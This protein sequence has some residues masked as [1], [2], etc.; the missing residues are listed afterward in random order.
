MEWHE[1]ELDSRRTV[2]F[3]ERTIPGFGQTDPADSGDYMGG[4]IGDGQW[5]W[6]TCRYAKD[7]TLMVCSMATGEC[8]SCHCFWREDADE[9]E[10]EHRSSI[11]CVEEL[12]PGEP[13]RSGLL[14][15]C[16]ESWPNGE[17]RPENCPLAS[18]QVLI[19]AI[20]SG[21][22]LRSFN[23]QDLHC[24]ALAFL[25]QRICGG[26]RLARFDGCLLVATEEGMVQLVDLNGS[27]LMEKRNSDYSICQSPSAENEPRYG[28]LYPV[29]C[30]EVI[31][32]IDVLLD[33][34]RSKGGHLAVQ[35]DVARTGIRCLMGI[36]IAPGFAA[37]LEDGRVLIYDL[38]RFNVTASL[39]PPKKEGR[40]HGAVE[41]MCL[42]MPPDDPKPCFYICVMYHSAER[43]NMLLHSVNYRRSYVEQDGDG[44]RFEHFHSS[45]VRNHQVFDGE[46]CSV[47]ACTTASTFSFA[48]D[49][50][51]LLIIMAWYST[52][53]RKNKLVLFDINQWYKDEMP[54]CVR[55]YEVPHYIAG[56]FLSQNGLNGLP[57]GLGLQL[58]PNSIMHFVS[59]QRYDEHFYPDSLTFDCKLLTP[60]GSR[61]YAQNGVQHRFLNALRWERAALF[62]R[63]QPYHEDIVRLRLLPQFCELNPNATFSKAAMY[64]VILSVALEHKCSALLNDCARSWLDGSFLCNMIE[65]TELSLSTLTN[66]IM[67]R[68]GQIKQRCAELCQG[69]FDYGGYSLD[70]RERRE[71]EILATQLRELLRLQTYIVELGT[72]RLSPTVLSECQTNRRALQTVHEFHRVLYW[73]IEQA[74]LPE[75]Q[76]EDHRQHREP[77]LVSLRRDYSE[78]RTLRKNLYIDTLT[79]Q[80]GLPSTYPPESLKALLLVMLE[81]Y[82]E[83]ASKH[84]LVL[85]L[86]LDLNPPL[87][88][89]FQAN[90]ELDE[91]LAKS[92]RSFWSLDRGDCTG[93]VNELY[94]DFAMS[95]NLEEWQT[96]LLLEGLL[97]AGAVKAAMRVVSQPP[98]PIPAALH[99][100][101]LLANGS[102]PEAFEKARLH[103]RDG[104]AGQSLLELFFRYC[105]ER[106]RFKVLAELC[107]REQE[108]AL[109]YRLLRQCRSRQTECVQ[110]ILLLQKSKFVEAVSLMDQVAAD[111]ER[112]ESS[113]TIISAYRSTMAP[114]AQNIAGT[115]MRIRGNLDGMEEGCPDAGPLLPFSCQL[116]QQN[117]SGQ[118]GGIFQSSAVSAHWATHCDATASAPV[119]MPSAIGYSNIPFL[120]HE[121]FGPP[122]HLQRLPLVKPVPHQSVEKRQREEQEEQQRKQQQSQSQ[123][124]LQPRKR[125][126][127]LAEQLLED[128]RGHIN[129]L[130]DHQS[131]QRELEDAEQNGASDLLQLPNFLHARQRTESDS[132][133]SS[134]AHQAIPTILKRQSTVTG[135]PPAATST[136]LA[137]PKRFRFMPP[138]P[139][140]L[141][142]SMAAVHE[143]K[144]EQEEEDEDETDEIIV[145]IESRSEPRSAD[146]SASDEFCSPM[147]SANV[148]LLDQRD[149]PRPMIPPAGPQPRSSLLQERTSI[150]S[151]VQRAGGLGT[152]SESSSGFGSFATVQPAQ[153]TSHSQFVPTV[154]S[155]KMGETQSQVFFAGSGLVRISERTT[156]CGEMESTELGSELMAAPSSQ[157]SLPAERPLGQIGQMMDTTLGMSTY[158]V[159]PE[160]QDDGDAEE[161]EEELKLGET[162]SPEQHNQQDEEEEGEQVRD[163]EQERS[164]TSGYQLAFLAN[165]SEAPATSEPLS[166]PTCSLSSEESDMSSA[167]IRNPLLPSLPNDD[168]MY[169]IVVESTGSITTSR[170]VTHTPTSFLPSDTNVSQN[171]SPRGAAHGD[172]DGDG[173]PISL[174]RANSLETVDDL[175]T[176]KGS[177]EEEEDGYDEDD[178]VIALDGTEVRGYVARPQ[179]SAACSSAELFA[180]K[181]DCQQQQ[182]QEEAASGP[183]PS[184]SLGAT[185]NSD[186]VVAE[187]I[188][189][190][191]D[192]DEEEEEE[193]PQP[194][195]DAQMEQQKEPDQQPME[196]DA[197]SND[198]VNTVAFS[199]PKQPM[200]VESEIELE[201][202]Q[203]GEVP[204]EVMQLERIPE[205]EAE[206]DEDAAAVVV[207]EDVI[208]MPTDEVIN[209]ANEHI[210][211]GI[212]VVAKEEE[213]I[214][215]ANEEVIEEQAEE[216]SDKP[217][218]EP[219]EKPLEEPSE[220]STPLVKERTEERKKPHSSE[221][222]RAAPL[223]EQEEDLAGSLVL[224]LSDDEEPAKAPAPRTRS[225]RSSNVDSPRALRPRRGSLEHSDSPVPGT[226][227]SH[228]ILVR[229]T[230]SPVS[231]PKRRTMQ[232]RHLLDVI[233]EQGSQDAWLPRTRSRSRLSVDSEGASSSRPATPTRPRERG[234][235]AVSLAPQSSEPV[236]PIPSLRHS[237]RGIS[238]PPASPASKKKAAAAAAAD[239]SPEDQQQPR[240]RR[241][242]RI[243]T[244]EQA[245]GSTSSESASRSNLTNSST[246]TTAT[247]TTH[248]ER[249]PRIRSRSKSDA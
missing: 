20:A 73:F 77:P 49:S 119:H 199:E 185:V 209:E 98:G 218:E 71:F 219:S 233:E 175:D 69:I 51:T 115:Y 178:C 171:S 226:G 242:A 28:E 137:E 146:S 172:N 159:Q 101:V 166:S 83:L 85:Y 154:C 148:S 23:L 236:K 183:R 41:R 216:P 55:P 70:E 138:I 193:K 147:A 176:T 245:S 121:Q 24:S 65:S 223:L 194:Q 43:L 145:E 27:S 141:D 15:I 75:G 217:L 72:R 151:G 35:V 191:S 230:A 142:G 91:D 187:T 107:L 92:V 1:G 93:C 136:T 238:E 110:L 212:N 94:K 64:E 105:I 8:I 139:L 234:K 17:L 60:T 165:S 29:L 57:M 42:I 54:S 192:E 74:L 6:V 186:S 198:S 102:M 167:G 135:A 104:G 158:D 58:H 18:T 45:S 14:A 149:S 86:L 143:D 164:E 214:K 249:R 220:E 99:M 26:T 95:V 125:R 80:T 170:S 221:A 63:P 25:D 46:N 134:I 59:L 227:P 39:Q 229:K 174:Y 34:S 128:V 211:E 127:L 66:W 11:R 197:G 195:P 122:D 200:V 10:Q 237:L 108:E 126:R 62:L 61:Y 21:R 82:T 177:L 76:H 89:R 161:E 235:R 78:R 48:G 188:V 225:R 201:V 53:E 40:I 140:R 9:Q 204:Q 189:V 240:L 215:V 210:S 50:G 162:Q 120:R 37:G 144:Q 111:R 103:D 22:V 246:T 133:P 184:L 205:E 47:I 2:A 190:D 13:E 36:S 160:S 222:S 163:Q 173:S 203:D 129:S 30:E 206:E 208:E 38:M 12:F 33:L 202:V 169:S 19:F 32:K 131:E 248:R 152:G 31:R 112:D 156:I 113:S 68:A 243:R 123:Y 106:R 114:V 224:V 87:S 124:S 180:F 168:P 116:V 81:P 79:G 157:W 150:G 4:I 182:Q 67:K 247:T 118:V 44:F 5:G 96:R 97:A 7:A 244:S 3:P 100:S 52:T 153:T 231:T 132:R 232:H 241:S 117:A 179:Q 84:A 196:E 56:Y 155:S 90:F 130:M 228:R 16:L 88:R 207:V 239:D 181:D 109:L 213:V